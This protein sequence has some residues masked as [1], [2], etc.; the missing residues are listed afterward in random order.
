VCSKCFKFFHPGSFG[1]H[2]GDCTDSLSPSTKKVQKWK[3]SPHLWANLRRDYGKHGEFKGKMSIWT[4]QCDDKRAYVLHP[5]WCVSSTLKIRVIC[6]TDGCT[7]VCALNGLQ[8][9]MKEHHERGDYSL[10]ALDI[11]DL[12]V[13]LRG[14][15]TGPADWLMLK[16]KLRIVEVMK[17][18]TT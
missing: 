10:R 1:Q 14:H 2:A 16:T 6:V 3:D 12:D 18:R 5:S 4:A 7:H 15:S 9:H 17:T 13:S 11:V 8:R